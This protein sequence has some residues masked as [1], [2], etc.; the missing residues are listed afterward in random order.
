MRNRPRFCPQ[1]SSYPEWYG[2]VNTFYSGNPL[3]RNA[4]VKRLGIALEL[5]GKYLKESDSILDVGAGPGFYFPAIADRSDAQV[6]DLD[7]EL[8]HL[9]AVR[10]MC[11]GES[12]DHRF[13]LIQ[14]DVGHLPLQDETFDLIYCF[15]VF[16]HI[17]FLSDALK[18]LARVLKQSGVLLIGIPIETLMSKV[19]RKVLGVGGHREGE[20][21]NSH[22][23]LGRALTDCFTIETFRKV[24]ANLVPDFVSIYALFLCRKKQCS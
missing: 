7:L 24:P 14:G 22:K 15:S 2:Y 6:V 3:V 5:T 11:L 1:R 10:Q 16:E 4:L 23:D 9:T 18:E 17:P 21:V 20:V 19:G 8:P 12:L 13:Q